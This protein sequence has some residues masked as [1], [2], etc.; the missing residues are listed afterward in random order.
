[1]ENIQNSI[2]ELAFMLTGQSRTSFAQ[3]DPFG[4]RAFCPSEIWNLFLQSVLSC[5]KEYP[6]DAGSFTTLIYNTPLWFD[7][8]STQE[9]EKL[10]ISKVRKLHL[11]DE[12]KK[13]VNI[14]IAATSDGVSIEECDIKCLLSSVY[15]CCYIKLCIIIA[16]WKRVPYDEVKS[17]II[18]LNDLFT[19]MYSLQ[20]EKVNS[21]LWLYSETLHPNFYLGNLDEFKNDIAVLRST[22][23]VLFLILTKL[24]IK[25]QPEI[26]LLN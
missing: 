25:Y 20:V 4:T 13:I 1:M 14:H 9:E 19:D 15:L 16:I 2:I 23:V 12:G 7:K 17:D 18:L 24:A 11:S 10:F 22:L 26:F 8:D 6:E 3:K 21:K 5:M